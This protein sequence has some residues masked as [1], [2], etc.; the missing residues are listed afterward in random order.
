M[1]GAAAYMGGGG[2]GGGGGAVSVQ[3]SSNIPPMQTHKVVCVLHYHTHTALA[4]AYCHK[5]FRMHDVYNIQLINL[6]K[7][8]PYILLKRVW[9]K[10]RL[11]PGDDGSDDN[12]SLCCYK[13]KAHLDE[14]KDGIS[15]HNEENH[16]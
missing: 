6:S 7:A 9:S 10:V 13:D 11:T 15:S 2:G 8:C 1:A 5:S 14:K 16:Q 4:R 12:I 3:R